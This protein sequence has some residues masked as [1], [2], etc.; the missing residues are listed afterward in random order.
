M[1]KFIIYIILFCSN[2]SIGQYIN[3]NDAT[4]WNLGF[5][6]GVT[7]QG[8]ELYLT[9]S[10][11]A[12]S[13]PFSGY[14]RGFTIGKSI[15][16]KKD[17]FFSFELRFRYLKGHNT[18]WIPI[19]DSFANPNNNSQSLFYTNDSIYA[20]HNYKMKLKEYFFEGVL[21]L[22]RLKQKTGF[23]LNTF[24][25]FGLTNYKIFSDK[26]IYKLIFVML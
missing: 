3:Y 19:A 10:D 8:S 16:K 15:Y 18:G 20:Y 17:K 21:S 22:N 14:S 25:G 7:M 13:R 11:S 12:Y 6:A 23:I 5:N 24:Y 1:K 26:T 4:G 2:I 9:N